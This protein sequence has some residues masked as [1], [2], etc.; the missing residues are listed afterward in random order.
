[1]KDEKKKNPNEKPNAKKRVVISFKTEPGSDVFI[2]VSFNDWAQDKKQLKDKNGDGDYTATLVLAPGIYEYK[3][4]VNGIWTLDPDPERDWTQ[5]A[6][7]TLNSV[8]RV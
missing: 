1:M 6:F 5:N 3:F 2:A 7:G 4:V 8:L